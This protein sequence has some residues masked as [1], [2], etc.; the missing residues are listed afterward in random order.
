MDTFEVTV[1][2]DGSLVVNTG[3]ITSGSA[4]PAN[5]LRAIPY[6]G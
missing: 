3:A 5:P 2:A 1:N 6:S 4:E